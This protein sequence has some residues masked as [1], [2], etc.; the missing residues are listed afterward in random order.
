M[1]KTQTTGGGYKFSPQVE[2]SQVNWANV[3]KQ[4]TDTLHN[5]FQAKEERRQAIEDGATEYTNSLQESMKSESGDVST[6]AINFSD[7]ASEIM[8]IAKNNVLSG[9]ISQREFN[10]IKNNLI[11]GAKQMGNLVKGYNAQFAEWEER[12]NKGLSMSIESQ[13]LPQQLEGFNNFGNKAGGSK[14]YVNPMTGKVSVG[15][16][17]DNNGV[18]EMSQN[19][20]DYAGVSTLEKRNKGKYDKFDSVAE[21]KKVTDSLG[22]VKEAILRGGVL[23]EE[24]YMQD[25]RWIDVI[26]QYVGANSQNPVNVASVIFD[27]IGMISLDANGKYAAPGTTGATLT[28]YEYTQ[29]EKVANTS[30][31]YILLTRGDYPVPDYDNDNWNQSARD[32]QKEEFKNFMSN[33]Y[34]TQVDK[35]QTAYEGRA[36]T[37]AEIDVGLNRQ[38]AI[39]A[40][41]EIGKIYSGDEHAIQA[42]LGNLTALM[43]GKVKFQTAH[44][45]KDGNLRLKMLTTSFNKN[46]G[47]E[48][49]KEDTRTLRMK[50]LSQAEFIKSAI[51]TFSP[52]TQGVDY[53]TYTSP[54]S[55]HDVSWGEAAKAVTRGW[56]TIGETIDDMYFPNTDAVFTLA[57]ADTRGRKLGGTE[58]TI[59]GL[60]SNLENVVW[61]EDNIGSKVATDV[62]FYKE[63]KNLIQDIP[64]R[65][66]N[67]QIKTPNLAEGVD[68]KVKDKTLNDLKYINKL[69]F[70]AIQAGVGL[71]Q[72]A[73][74]A[75]LKKK[76]IAGMVTFN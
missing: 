30:D 17:I 54:M 57:K 66:F 25:P 12:V 1:A 3:S 47:K 46:T 15:K 75:K 41:D 19:P 2:T 67:V 34:Q 72:S 74:E 71:N 53:S 52:N 14:P 64:M 22:K 49:T 10:I 55:S 44:R 63:G 48:E 23:D 11:H 56:V 76:G 60:I 9:A 37:K 32:G 4:V 20:T 58:V 27:D 7:D 21:A 16:M 68:N 65:G 39:D 38:Q 31:H 28:R 26:D 73:I 43:G 33:T 5:E 36:R 13:F 40:A 24:N 8:S 18:L 29:D 59:D 69:L 45:E 35:I 62:T 51:T 50:G 70:S 42:A 6:M 61:T